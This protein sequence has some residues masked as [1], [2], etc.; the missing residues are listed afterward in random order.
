MS[1][2][3]LKPAAIA[4]QK[5]TRGE[6][7]E[8]FRIIMHQQKALVDHE[9]VLAFLLQ[10]GVY[11]KEEFNAWYDQQVAEYEAKQKPILEPKVQEAD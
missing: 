11:T 9:N 2:R 6:L 4:R 8:M 10:K 1:K 7:A 5:A 3:Q